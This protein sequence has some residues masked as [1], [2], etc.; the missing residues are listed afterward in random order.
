MER[1]PGDQDGINSRRDLN[2]VGV[3]FASID[4]ARQTIAGL[5][6]L[7]TSLFTVDFEFQFH[8]LLT[9]WGTVHLFETPLVFPRRRCNRNVVTF[10]LFREAVL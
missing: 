3:N 6:D 1:A 7:N 5:F 8:G 10:F 9:I 2:R 4:G